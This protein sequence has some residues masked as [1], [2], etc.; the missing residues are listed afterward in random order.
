MQLA[1]FRHLFPLPPRTFPG[2]ALA[3]LLPSLPRPPRPQ[4]P[5]WASGKSIVVNNTSQSYGKKGL[6]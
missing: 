1:G 6:K 5:S 2:P 3:S 4:L